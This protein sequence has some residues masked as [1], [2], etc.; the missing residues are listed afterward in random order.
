MGHR[1]VDQQ[2]AGINTSS[3]FFKYFFLIGLQA[4][5]TLKRFADDPELTINAKLDLF[6]F[7]N[8]FSNFNVS[9]AIVICPDLST[10]IPSVKSFF[11]KAFS[12]SG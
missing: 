12:K 10:L 4:A 9:E 5:A 2:I 1:E 11:E 8:F 3:F 7:A 6:F